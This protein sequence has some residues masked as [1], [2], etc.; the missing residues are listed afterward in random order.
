MGINVHLT[1]RRGDDASFS[2]YLFVTQIV[3]GAVT[4]LSTAIVTG[5]ARLEAGQARLAALHVA[6]DTRNSVPFRER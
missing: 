2:S 3:R 4:N 5:A 6:L 1:E